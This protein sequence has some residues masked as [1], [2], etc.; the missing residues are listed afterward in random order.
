MSSFAQNQKKIFTTAPQLSHYFVCMSYAK[1]S[2]HSDEITHSCFGFLFY[3]FAVIVVALGYFAPL[4]L[5]SHT[6]KYVGNS[7]KYFLLFSAYLGKLFIWT[8]IC[9]PCTSGINYRHLQHDYILDYR[10]NENLCHP[11]KESQSL[12]YT[13][14]CNAQNLAA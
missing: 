13:R 9:L 14:E 4:F 3:G 2:T 8:A 1:R 7:S 11:R 10:R 6:F 5:R 12:E